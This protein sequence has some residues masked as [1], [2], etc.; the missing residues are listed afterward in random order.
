MSRPIG[1]IVALAALL[2]GC[3]PES[4]PSQDPFSVFG[5]TRIEPAPTCG[6]SWCA[7]TDPGYRSGVDDGIGPIPE[8]GAFSGP[9]PASGTAPQ[10]DAAGGSAARA[11]T[12]PSGAT[13]STPPSGATESAPRWTPRGSGGGGQSTSSG[14]STT[15]PRQGDRPLSQTGFSEQRP[16]VVDI[17]DLPDWEDGRPAGDR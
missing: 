9:G 6:G 13:E 17:T 16:Q 14:A 8:S 12:P 10:R 3:C 4:R 15:P 5:P 7:P 2:S 1:L 11:S